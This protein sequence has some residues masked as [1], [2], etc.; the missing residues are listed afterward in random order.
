GQMPFG[1]PTSEP[2]E[3]QFNFTEE[4]LKVFK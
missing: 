2:G 3:K 1:K 4:H